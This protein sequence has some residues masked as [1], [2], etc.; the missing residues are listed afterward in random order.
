[1]P[2]AWG[3]LTLLLIAKKQPHMI[4]FME[5]D[6]PPPPFFAP[7]KLSSSLSSCRQLVSASCHTGKNLVYSPYGYRNLPDINR[8]QI[9]HG[10]EHLLSLLPRWLSL[11]TVEAPYNWE[12]ENFP[13]QYS[14]Q[15]TKLGVTLL[16]TQSS[17]QHSLYFSSL[18]CNVNIL[19]LGILWSNISDSSFF[20][21]VSCKPSDYRT[22]AG[23][24]VRWNCAKGAETP[25]FS[26]RVRLQVQWY[27]I[28][29]FKWSRK[30]ILLR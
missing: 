13:S 28:W 9:A 14:S 24:W 7:S 11:M 25:L 2:P 16:M 30:S 22:K 5:T 19:S 23:K 1:M 10:T 20:S 26:S 8:F 29:F 12:V 27:P 3:P 4:A 21:S 18:L 15:R 6:F 17:F